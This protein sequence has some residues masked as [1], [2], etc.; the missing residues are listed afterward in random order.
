MIYCMSLLKSN[1]RNNIIPQCPPIST[2]FISWLI[3]LLWLNHEAMHR[4]SVQLAKGVQTHW[5]ME[6][7]QTA[8]PGPICRFLFLFKPMYQWGFLSHGSPIVTIGFS[9]TSGA[10]NSTPSTPRFLSSSGAPR[11][12]HGSPF[13]H[14][15]I[16][17]DLHQKTCEMTEVHSTYVELLGIPQKLPNSISRMPKTMCPL[18]IW[19]LL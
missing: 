19:G 17:R 15:N 14:Q 5:A 13:A 16:N 7:R 2:D 9:T 11:M 6:F 1:I 3:F 10:G 4:S 18:G 8:S 12:S